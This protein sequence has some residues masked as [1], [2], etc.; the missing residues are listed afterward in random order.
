MNAERIRLRGRVQ[1]VGFRPTVA[2]L[3]AELG[4]SG[5]V[6]N[7]S[8]GVE[9]ALGGDEAARDRFLAALTAGLPPLAR[10]EEI[11]R[12]A[13]VELPINQGFAILE[14]TR[15]DAAPSA[16]VI[17]DAAQCAA[18][19]AE[20]L[21]PH[22]R[23]FRYPFTNCTHCGPRFTI[24]TTVP[25]D[26][27]RT[28]MHAFPLC[29]ACRLEYEDPSD[30]RYHAEPIACHAC[31]PRVTLSRADRRAFATDSMTMLDAVDAVATLIA[32]GEI[33]ALKGLGGF[34]LLCDATSSEAVAKLRA[35]KHRPDKP[36]ALI[37]RDLAV[38]E[39]YCELDA[40]ERA[41]LT[42][43]AAPIVLLAARQPAPA[44]P[45]APEVAP[46]PEGAIA[47][48]GMMLPAT[49]LHVLALR[50]C[51]RPVVCTSGNRSEEPQVIDDDDA[52][53]RL[54]TIADWIVGHDR[55]IHSRV[56]DS[57]VRVVAGRPRIWRRARGYAP[58]PLALPPGFEG[59]ARTVSV[60]AAGSDLKSTVCLSRARDLV[61]SQHL[62]DLDDALARAAYDEQWTRLS[63]L[64]DHRPT[65][66]A[67]DNHP[68]SRAG[69]HG[70]QRAE[71][72]GLAVIE[73]PHHHAHFAACL[74]EHRIPRDA[75]PHVGLILDGIG[76]GD[77]GTLWGGEVLIGGYAHAERA[78][79]L[80][81]VALLGGD[82]AAREPWRCLYA[83]LRAEA[84]WGELVASF[85]DVPVI[86]RL[87]AKPTDALDQMLRTGLGAP[88]ASSCG[89]LFDAVAAALDLS[90]EAQSHEAQA[91]M[92]LE[93]LVTPEALGR[94][95][96]E[97]A[98]NEIYP[99]P[100]P[101]IRAG[102]RG[103]GL[104]YLEPLGMWRAI[105]GD[106][107]T[108]ASHALI[109]ARFHVALAAGLA[110]LVDKAVRARIAASLPIERTVALSG[111]CLQNAVLHQRL[112]VELEAL[113]FRVLT[114]AEV[115][116]NDGGIAFGQALVALARAADTS[117]Q[118]D[119][120]CA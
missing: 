14:S 72:A 34:H 110:Q 87:R 45:I 24:A 114:H 100:A 4:M 36:F 37:A 64:F 119:T 9:L 82:R 43:P 40:H 107:A 19:A 92:A 26:R 89:R 42:S 58:S 76:A 75:A 60:A 97:R 98:E 46:L 6:K 78:A 81:P 112:V 16:T 31:G 73:I 71:D 93:A 63:A 65:V 118:E 3:A 38:I 113:E 12:G 27:A 48:H 32:R 51:T 50:R 53:A 55:P 91:A 30:R 5:W 25:W 59:V 61:L 85:G 13:V 77:D 35:R 95:L 54:G 79:C 17:P 33:V 94:A 10:I 103:A 102:E 8:E 117:H 22:A 18:C 28:T 52:F 15:G 20:V 115:P 70:R 7:D 47:R 80:K 57:V 74:G 105:L 106:L 29:D 11:V 66:V 23:R 111:G 90:F 2:R 120:S 44:R 108:G 86:A 99:L 88:R 62:G 49:P 67:V 96:A 68:D 109:A 21:D 41:A 69:A 56:D 84:S 83:H 116:A 101:L 104:P 1:G 39:A